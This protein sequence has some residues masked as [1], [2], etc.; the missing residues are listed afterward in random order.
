MVNPP[1]N[2]PYY[3]EN[4]IR[5]QTS[6]PLRK[7]P[8]IQSEDPGAVPGHSSGQGHSSMSCKYGTEDQPSSSAGQGRRNITMADRKAS[9]FP[10]QNFRTFVFGQQLMT[11]MHSSAKFI[12]FHLTYN[13]L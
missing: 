12:Q 10:T 11:V 5:D 8:H 1:P 9:I 13:I 2:T 3:T 7:K 6:S 4:P